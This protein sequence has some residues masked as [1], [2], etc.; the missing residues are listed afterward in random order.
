M[1][2]LWSATRTRNYHEQL[3]EINAA[4]QDL[5]SKVEKLPTGSY[6]QRTQSGLLSGNLYFSRLLK[7]KISTHCDKLPR[8]SQKGKGKHG[9]TSDW[10]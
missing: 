7:E 9:K 10:S 3:Q 6:D 8:S 1:P 4:L 2:R 5:L